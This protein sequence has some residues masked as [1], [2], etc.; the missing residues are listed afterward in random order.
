[1]TEKIID[2]AISCGFK[3]I[4]LTVDAPVLGKRRADER[5]GFVLPPHLSGLGKNILKIG[6]F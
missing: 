4:V 5:N 1:M 3:A 2:R 6:H